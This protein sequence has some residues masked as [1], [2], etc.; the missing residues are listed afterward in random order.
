[1]DTKTGCY[2][3]KFNYQKSTLLSCKH[4]LCQKCLLRTLLKRHMLELPD[5]ETITIACKC[6]NGSIDLSLQKITEILKEKPEISIAPCKKHNMDIIK[7]CKDCKKYLCE[8]CFESHSDLFTDHHCIN[9]NEII[10]DSQT[11]MGNEQCAKHIK[12]YESYCK[13]CKLSLC[14]ICLYDTKPHEGHELIPYHDYQTKINDQMQKLQFKSYESFLE[15][16]DKMEKDF[17]VAYNMNLANTTKTLESILNLIKTTL[18]EYQKKMEAKFTKKNLIMNIIKKVYQRYYEDFKIAN[19]NN[20]LL[21]LK[22][23]SK[24]YSEFSELNFHSD[25]DVITGKLAAIKNL[26][27]NEDLSNSVKV[28]YAYFSKKELKLTTKIQNQQ[29]DQIND[30]IELKDGKIVSASEDNSICVFGQ[31]GTCLYILNGHL[32]GVRALC[33]LGNNRFASGSADKTIR[34]W[35]T[36]NYK[37]LHILKEHSNPII[38]LSLLAGEKMASCSFREVIVYDHTF[39]PI[40]FLKEHTNW[41]RNCIQIDK[42]KAAT[43][44]DDGTIKI[45]DKHFRCLNTFKDHQDSV[46]AICKLRDGRFVSGDRIGKMIIWSKNLAYSKEIKQHTNAI[47][48]IKQ[49][50]DGRIVSGSVD[51]TIR[52]WDLDFQSISVF[53]DHSRNVNSLYPLRDGGLASAGG[54]CIVNI[55]R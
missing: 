11:K 8:K 33:V 40:Y 36:K 55:W 13:N 35:E 31:N 9:K 54:D 39:K 34:V 12:D 21:I 1:M 48:C 27:E 38:S 16:I 22:F 20:N 15:Y 24:P 41:V 42:F 2:K 10:S 26:I 47:L 52:L 37:T 49:I 5:K 6:K 29:K 46:L 18:G 43:C 4:Y 32:S 3:C 25:F 14:Q 7:Y 50:K 53:T 51:H 45:Y 23:L 17:N 28:S 19:C 30:V 44:S